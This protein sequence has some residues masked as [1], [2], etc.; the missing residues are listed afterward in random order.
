MMLELLLGE[1]SDMVCTIYEKDGVDYPRNGN[2]LFF[3]G[4]LR[5]AEKKI[6]FLHVFFSLG[7]YNRRVALMW[8]DSH[9]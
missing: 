8:M 4:G 3:H 2:A 6:A 7:V 9:G 5:C 1:E